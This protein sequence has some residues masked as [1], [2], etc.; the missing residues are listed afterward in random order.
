MSFEDLFPAIKPWI[1]TLPGLGKTKIFG[2]T[3]LLDVFAVFGAMHLVGVALLGGCSILLNLRFMGA[4]LIDATPARIERGLR[5]WLITG[6]VL[7]LLSGLVMGTLTAGKVY[8]SAPFFSKMLALAAALIFSFGVSNSIAR[9][10]GAISRGAMVA[11]VIGML[12]WFASFFV[13]AVTPVTNVSL[14]HLS[15]ACYAI[16]LIFGTNRT[17]VI[18]AATYVLLHGGVFV[19]Y[20]IVGFNVGYDPSEQIWIDISMYAVLAGLAVVIALLAYELYKGR[21]GAAGPPARLI[22]FFSILA[23]ITVAAGGRWIGFS[24]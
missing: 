24:P 6:I 17:R 20:W 3:T 5:I 8:S 1:E 19:M 23:W 18:A 7:A 22:A 14:F 12:F 9:S 21:A 15:T 4:G 16:L 2:E 11:A 13:L 10:D